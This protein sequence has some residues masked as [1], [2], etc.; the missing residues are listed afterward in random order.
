[1]T[2]S[3]SLVLKPKMSDF[4]YDAIKLYTFQLSFKSYSSVEVL[5]VSEFL[6]FF[7]FNV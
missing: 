7:N 2:Y 5:C 1:M 6:T 4:S 3:T